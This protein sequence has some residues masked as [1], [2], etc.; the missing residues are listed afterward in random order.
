MNNIQ[1][2]VKLNKNCIKLI[3]IIPISFY[4]YYL[5]LLISNLSLRI[6]TIAID[7]SRSKNEYSILIQPPHSSHHPID[8]SIVVIF[9]LPM[10]RIN[11]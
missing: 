3:C 2:N 1:L 5:F 11:N 7:T 6:T 4:F 9:F 10:R 8:Q